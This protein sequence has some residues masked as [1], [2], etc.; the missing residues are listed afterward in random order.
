[1]KISMLNKILI[2]KYSEFLESIDVEINGNRPWDL[3]VHNPDLF[4]SI[5]FNGSLGFGESYM[6]G[7]F[8]C[9]RLDLFFE[10][11]LKQGVS[12]EI[13]SI[14]LFLGRVKSK[15]RN[16]Q[17]ISRAFQVAEQHYDI[18]N[19]LF[20]LMLDKTMMYTCGYWTKDVNTLE[21]SQLAKLDLVA[22]KLDLKPGMKVLDIGCGWGG[23]AKHFANNYGVNVVGITVSKEQI[24]YAKE[25]SDNMDVDFRLVDYRD[26]NEKFDAIYSI[27]MFEAVGYK[28]YREF[29]E[30]VRGCLKDDGAFLLHTI[31]GNESTT[32]TDPWVEKYIFPNGMIPSAEQITKASE[33]LFIFD[34]WHNIGPH[35]DKTLMCWYENFVTNYEKLKDKY[36][37]E[38]YRMWTFWLLSSAANFRARTLQ[39]WQVL[40]SLEG[41]ERPIQT[42][43]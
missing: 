8:D 4:K 2:D 27:G 21:E 30:I 26:L 12:T 10:K 19:D 18:G 29:F 34:D 7:W 17:S 16:L 40:F 14:P 31:G 43:R 32:T 6:K 23:A 38:F 5:L 20:S 33:G 36:D 41:T 28:N 3:T 25:N 11:V 37:K 24:A 22:K 13:Q 9:E 1:M 39:L 35:Y 42:Y 15:F